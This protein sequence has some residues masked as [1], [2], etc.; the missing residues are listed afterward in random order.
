V[1]GSPRVVLRRWALLGA[2]VALAAALTGACGAQGE[3]PAAPTSPGDATADRS[4]RPPLRP[5][6]SV[7]PEAK[8]SPDLLAISYQGD[9]AQLRSAVARFGGSIVRADERI[10]LYLARFPP[11][12]I[13]ALIR[14]RD[15][16]R[17]EGIDAALTPQ[18]P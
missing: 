11:R 3:E 7:P 2:A 5:G 8:V 15:A 16:L 10:H 1:T 6:P 14:I 13:E 4:A 9:L 17:A 18:L 12:G